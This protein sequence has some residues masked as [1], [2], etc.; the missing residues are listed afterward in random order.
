MFKKKQRKRKEEKRKEEE[1]MSG[2]RKTHML[3]LNP[4]PQLFVFVG[5]VVLHCVNC[6]AS[7]FCSSVAIVSHILSSLP[8]LSLHLLQSK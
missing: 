8:F 2:G 6:H 3:L 4:N 5:F 7:M 1:S